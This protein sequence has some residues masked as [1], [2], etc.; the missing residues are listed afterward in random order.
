VSSVIFKE[1]PLTMMYG[2]Y[3]RLQ[4]VYWTCP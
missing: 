2:T 3:V 1:M 4:Y